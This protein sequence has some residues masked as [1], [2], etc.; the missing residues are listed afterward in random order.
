MNV[1][2]ENMGITLDDLPKITKNFDLREY[3]SPEVW[4]KYGQSSIWFVNPVLFNLM[5]FH[6]EMLCE[7]YGGNVSIIMN[8]WHVGGPRKWSGHRTYSYIR[9]QIKKGGRL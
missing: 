6:K 1:I 7:E 8:N 5:Q 9:N 4:N 3:V 2:L